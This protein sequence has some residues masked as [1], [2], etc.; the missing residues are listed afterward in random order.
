MMLGIHTMRYLDGKEKL[1]DIAVSRI[2]LTMVTNGYFQFGT[3]VNKH[4]KLIQYL[5]VLELK[6]KNLM[7]KELA[8][9]Q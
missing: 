7:E 9:K 4:D 3:K 5:L 1:E 2:A 6:S 8:C